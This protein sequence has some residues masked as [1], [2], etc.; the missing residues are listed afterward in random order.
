MSSS[1]KKLQRHCGKCGTGCAVDFRKVISKYGAATSIADGLGDFLHRW[2][3]SLRKFPISMSEDDLICLNASM[4]MADD[5][6]KVEI[7]RLTEKISEANQMLLK[8]V[9]HCE[10]ELKK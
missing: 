10:K 5:N 3:E 6:I 9:K 8:Y 7:D 1:E 2:Q 4:T